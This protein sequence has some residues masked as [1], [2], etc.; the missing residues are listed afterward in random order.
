[1]AEEDNGPD[2]AEHAEAMQTLTAWQLGA[3]TGQLAQ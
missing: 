2:R 1:M 3:L